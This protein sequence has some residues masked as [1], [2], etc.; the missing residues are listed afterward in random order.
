MQLSV[1]VLSP[2]WPHEERFE[3]KKKKRKEKVLSFTPRCREREDL[4]IP[5]PKKNECEPISQPTKFA[6]ALL[7]DQPW[8]EIEGTSRCFKWVTDERRK[9]S[10][11]ATAEKRE[12]PGKTG[13]ACEKIKVEVEQVERI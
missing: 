2:E 8:A 10:G 7:A 1:T 13:C 5:Q 4:K 11:R 6:D 3:T 9:V 12:D